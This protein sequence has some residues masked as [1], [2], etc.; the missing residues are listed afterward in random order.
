[1]NTQSNWI[2]WREFEPEALESNLRSLRKRHTHAF[3]AVEPLMRE[4]GLLL[5]RGVGGVI[6]AAIE[7]AG[8]T[9]PAVTAEDFQRDHQP[10]LSAL[11][12][13]TPPERPNLILVLGCDLGAA[14]DVLK[15]HLRDA[16][17]KAIL[18][19]E[20][21]ARYLALTLGSHPLTTWLESN[22]VTWAAG[23]SWSESFSRIFW[24]HN[25]FTIDRPD[26]LF[27]AGA[28]RVDRLSCWTPLQELMRECITLGRRQFEDQLA[29]A[30]AYYAHKPPTQIKTI[31]APSTAAD[32]GKAIPY[33]Q[34]R[35]L[36][37]CRKLGLSVIHHTPSFRGDIGLLKRIARDKP[38]LMLFINRSA[39]E[40][41]ERVTLDRLRLPR[42]IWCIDD[43][44]CFMGDAFNQHDFVF[45]WD[46]HYSD[47]LKSKSAREVDHFPYVADMDGALPRVEERFISPVSYIGQVKT[48]DAASLGLPPKEA[49][50]AA[51]IGERKAEDRSRSYESLIFEHQDHFGVRILETPENE[52]PRFFRYAAYVVANARWRIAAL[53]RAAPFGLK[54][55]GNEDWRVYLKDD[56]LLDCFQGPADP[57]RDAPS[58]FMSSA[59]NLNIHSLQALTSLNQRDFNCPLVGGFLLTDWVDGADHFFRPGQEMVFYQNLDD[60]E[61]KIR[62]YLE[63]PDEREPIVRAGQARVMCDHTYAVRTPRVLNT[64]VKRIQERY[65]N[66]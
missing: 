39:G 8:E 22:R 45:T 48:L 11:N 43:P 9:T 56:S 36:S 55:Y 17:D 65:G 35:F 15:R 46:E 4:S 30:E 66:G 57:E 25:F 16:P 60:L 51:W 64:L 63:H 2:S 62:H 26:V 7:D 52:A 21:D 40:F 61:N 47:Y 54:F 23:E 44:T 20:P 24:D 10:M 18:I 42:M 31:L 41:A 34:E 6:E 37:E 58:I 50:F 27:A 28:R 19:V 32:P 13:F 5:R 49:E 12:A 3:A 1:M 14:F 53:R 33:I 38:D 59:I 29:E